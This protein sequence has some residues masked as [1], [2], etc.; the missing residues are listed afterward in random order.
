M[1]IIGINSS[2]AAPVR[3][4]PAKSRQLADGGAALLQKG[5]ISCAAIEERFTRIRYAAG[6]RESAINC[7]RQGKIGLD[8]LDAVGHSTCCD[9]AWSNQDDLIEDIAETL[10]GHHSRKQ[11]ESLRGKVFPVDHHES[12]AA[13]AFACS[14]FH[15]ALVAVI[16]GMGN[17]KGPPGEFNVSADWW[18]GAFQRHDYYICEWRDGR[19]NF[20]KVHED[21]GSVDEIGI[22]EIYR[23]V[24]HFLG[25]PTYQHAGKTMAL[26]PWGNPER[27]SA[28]PLIELAP[29]FSTRVPVPN[30]HDNPI[31]Q[32][33]NAIRLAGY[34]LPNTSMGTASPE[35][36]L[37]CDVAALVQQQLESVIVKAV[38]SLAD[39]L[40]LA[41][42][43]FG[44]GVA[45][46]C[47]ALG[48]LAALRPDLRLYVPPAPADTGLALGNA[49]WLA[50]AANSPVKEQLPFSAIKSAALGVEYHSFEID[51]AVADFVENHPDVVACR[52][53]DAELL[54]TRI[55]SDLAV[56][57]VV[58]LRQGRSEYG[59]RALGNSSIIADPRKAEMHDIVN[60][61]KRR[62]PFRPYAPSIL[63]EHVA[64][65]FEIHVPSPYMGFAGLI[66]EEKR[67]LIP[68]VVH[69]DGSARYQTVAPGA[70]FFR[71]LLEAWQR[72]TGVPV[73]LNTSFNMNGEPIV[74]TPQDALDCFE[75][76]RLPVLVLGNWHLERPGTIN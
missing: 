32:V 17:R 8:A 53:D 61:H 39:E 75:R 11:V 43:A 71:I 15:K 9:V 46:N 70:G 21:A 35:N 55:A 52:Y 5:K 67:S 63:S 60:S 30:M 24:T 12:H 50:Y 27:L 74:E 72:Q 65:Y 68:A 62:E 37:L 10:E 2:R 19:I 69:V 48:K 18:R 13:I 33:G 42:I 57:K 38:S 23:S 49:L 16:D 41:N 36:S 58:G 56:G 26:A 51:S 47:V 28:T 29:P 45:M 64:E 40:G 6:F 7:L 25:W 31:A 76:S 34:A 14:G 73:L 4:D 22:G 20:E 66:R 44:G 59:P 54:A 1:N 3:V